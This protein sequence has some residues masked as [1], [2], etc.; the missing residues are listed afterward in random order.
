MIVYYKIFS[1]VTTVIV[2]YKI[3]SHATDF[4]WLYI[5]TFL[6]ILAL[7]KTILVL[8]SKRIDT[9]RYSWNTANVGDKHQSIN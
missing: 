8:H 9:P 3:F 7:D 1:Q 2:Y 5:W 6:L 4:S